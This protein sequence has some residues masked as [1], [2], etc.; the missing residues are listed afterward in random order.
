MFPAGR[1]A[2]FPC[3]SLVGARATVALV[4]RSI[5]GA[6][7]IRQLPLSVAGVGK[8]PK[9][10][11]GAGAAQ[12]A[13]PRAPQP[14]GT[15]EVADAGLDPDPHQP[16]QACLWAAAHAASPAGRRPHLGRAWD[17]CLHLQR[18]TVVAG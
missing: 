7:I 4:A 6:G 16:P 1:L 11:P 9:P 3:R 17:L 2:T 10:D 15:L 14:K 13:K 8:D 12:P 18:I 5:A